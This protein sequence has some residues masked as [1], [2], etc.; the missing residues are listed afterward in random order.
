[1]TCKPQF[2][3]NFRRMTAALDSK[4]VTIVLE[5]ADEYHA[6]GVFDCIENSK[7]RLSIDLKL[8]LAEPGQTGISLSRQEP[9]DAV[10]FPVRPRDQEYLNKLWRIMLWACLSLLIL[11]TSRFF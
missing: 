5:M 7:K 2:A 8:E 9:F 11:M 10:S 3:G 4:N 6:M 1:M